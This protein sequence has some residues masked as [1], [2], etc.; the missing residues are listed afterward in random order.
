MAQ[1]LHRETSYFEPPQSGFKDLGSI[2]GGQG[3]LMNAPV[4]Y[5]ETNMVLW[6]L[7]TN[8]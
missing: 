7:I 1:L 3:K 4:F 5:H 8:V 2:P 6:T